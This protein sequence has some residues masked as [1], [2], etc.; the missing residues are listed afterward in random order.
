MA[1]DPD[2]A[3]SSSS[4]LSPKIGLFFPDDG[5]EEY[6]IFIEKSVLCKVTS[7]ERAL[8]TWFSLFYVFDLQY[9]KEAKEVCLFFQ[10]FVF[11][12]PDNSVAKSSTYLSITTDIQSITLH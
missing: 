3:A 9:S 5:T 11:G 4:T 1:D 10:E 7:F 6:F 2:L 12:I 8:F